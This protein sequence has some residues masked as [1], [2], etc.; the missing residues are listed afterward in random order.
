MISGIHLSSSEV[1]ISRGQ[2]KAQAI[3]LF[4]KDQIVPAKVLDVLSQGNA[5]LLIN[6]RVLTAKT[7]MLLRPGEEIRLKVLDEKDSVIL[8]L[9]GPVQ[10]ITLSQISSLIRF[11]SGKES[12]MD[13]SR[14]NMQGMKD[15]LFD[16]SLKS[17]DANSDFLPDLMEK[18]GLNFEHKLTGLFDM[19]GSSKDIQQALSLLFKQNLKALIQKELFLAGPDQPVG[20]DMAASLSEL[21]ENLQ[22]LN[23]QGGEAG[24]Y[25]LPLPVFSGDIF[26]FGQLFIDTGGKSGSE[27]ESPSDRLIQVSF[28]LDMSHLGPL[29]A[30]FSILKKEI[31]GRFFFK[32][33]DICHYVQSMLPDLRERLEKRDYSVREIRCFSDEKTG[34]EPFN[35]IERLLKAGS[36]RVL[37]IVI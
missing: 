36:D 31:S 8:K 23:H 10:K 30:D 28:L 16:I 18:I 1:L 26:R 34:L 37:N 22:I 9:V 33:Q 24:R 19:Q 5:R 29:R 27:P 21:L 11:F 6:N 13:I 7:D 17:G 12:A 20:N 3:P 32:D 15:L 4:V 2:G 25:L 14:M 35:L